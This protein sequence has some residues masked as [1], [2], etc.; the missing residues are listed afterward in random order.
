MDTHEQH[1]H[2]WR[3]A[4]TG[5]GAFL[6]RAYTLRTTAKAAANRWSGTTRRRA[7]AFVRECSAGDDCPRPPRRRSTAPG[8]RT[9]TA[10]PPDPY[11]GS[12]GAGP[13]GHNQSG[14]GSHSHHGSQSGHGSGVGHGHGTE[15]H[16][17]PSGVSRQ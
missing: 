4:A 9:G 16:T 15:R 12:R 11:S 14:H 5:T 1:W 10:S 13:E 3:V 7:F 17:A 8:Q 2:V 6:S